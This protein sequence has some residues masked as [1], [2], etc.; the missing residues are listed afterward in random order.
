MIKRSPGMHVQ[1]RGLLRRWHVNWRGRWYRLS[2][3]NS[4]CH[5]VFSG[6]YIPDAVYHCRIGFSPKGRLAQF[7]FYRGVWYRDTSF[8]EP[9]DL[10]VMVRAEHERA[11]Q[12]IESAKRYVEAAGR[13]SSRTG[14][15]PIPR[16]VQIL[17]WQRDQ[18]KCV[19]CGS[20]ANLEFDHII[21]LSRG[22]ANSA[23]NIQ[24]L[25]QTCNRSKGARIGV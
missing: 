21:P 2:G 19:R 17:V 14:R 11:A 4:L 25:C 5:Q 6:D 23:R 1:R 7:A 16:E 18:G 10:N 3:G 9:D 22:G 24:L 12:K 13:T 20:N 15:E 8:L